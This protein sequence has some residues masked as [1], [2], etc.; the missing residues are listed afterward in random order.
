MK[1]IQKGRENALDQCWQKELENAS[2]RIRM[3]R[4]QSLEY[5]IRQQ[6]EVI[7]ARRLAGMAKVAE[8]II[9]EGYY[10]SIY[11]IQKGFNISDTFNV[12]EKSTVESIISK[13][14]TPDGKDFSARIWEDR[15][16]LVKELEKELTHSF[17][18]GDAPDKAISNV[19]KVMNVSKKNAGRLVMTES[20]YFASASRVQAYKGLG[21]EEY[22][23]SATLDLQT[24][25]ICQEMDGK[26][27][28]ISE[29]QPG[30]TANPFH[31]WCR[32]S[33]TPYFEGNV[34]SRFMRDPGTGKSGS[35][36]EYI[37]YKDW[38]Q[39][40]VVDKYGQE[41]ADIMRKK[42][43]NE[44]SDFKQYQRYM[45]LLGNDMP[46]KSFAEFQ[47]LKYNKV[48]EWKQLQ[49]AY[50]AV[51]VDSAKVFETAK[52]GGRHSGIYNDA[53]SK[54]M[55]QLDRTI[56]SHE[57]Q[58]SE[59][60]KKITNPEKYDINWSNKSQVEKDGLLRKWEKDMTRNKEQA[61]IEKLVREERGQVE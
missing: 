5:Q 12:L 24:S 50:R 1:N 28:K 56:R 34:K 14:W 3:S 31:P 29:Y 44:T 17:I 18:R 10:K 40:Y 7:T 42:L 4:L 19:A 21:V 33:T 16:K 51:N 53:M 47:E 43:E 9:E 59:H 52:S 15:D 27:F 45:K 39:K 2:T 23:I 48:D 11:E 49:R 30:V 32:T 8:D 35:T 20:A 6:V 41:Q 26:V 55:N 58:V 46:A 61:E 60:Y 36:G 57:K 37:I 13:P 54:T 22:R 25:K 38:Y